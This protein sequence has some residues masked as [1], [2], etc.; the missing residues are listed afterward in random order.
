MLLLNPTLK[1]T[2]QPSLEQRSDVMDARHDF[3]SLF[4]AS[5]NGRNEM[6]VACGRK[7]GIAS[8]SVRVDSRT[9]H[10]RHSSGCY[11][12]HRKEPRSQWLAR[13]L[14]HRSSR[15][16]RIDMAGTAS[17]RVTRYYQR[18]PNNTATS[19]NESVWPAQAVDVSATASL[20]T[21]HFIHFF[22]CARVFICRFHAPC[23]QPF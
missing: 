20:G 2:E 11:K 7:P 22:E 8:P 3:V 16:R 17:Q 13:V 9:R 19:A 6:L 21:K 14:K 10:L 12:P 5:A 23:Y 1:R 18:L 15:Q 4:D